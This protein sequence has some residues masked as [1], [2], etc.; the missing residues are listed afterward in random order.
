MSIDFVAQAKR[1]IILS[2]LF[3]HSKI[4]HQNMEHE[5]LFGSRKKR[6]HVTQDPW[7]LSAPLLWWAEGSPWTVGDSFQGTQIFGSTGSGKSSGSIATICRAFM[8]AGYGGLFLT[9]KA[10]DRETY[11]SYAKDAGRLDDVLVF[12][13][14]NDLKYNFI[15]DEQSQ[16]RG[17]DALVENL[18]ALLMTVTDLGSSGNEGGGGDNDKYFKLEGTRLARNGLLA[19]VLAGDTITIP[20]LHRLIVSSPTS[21]EQVASESWQQSSF[22]FKCL[23][24]ADKAEKTQSQ[25]AD[26]EL[27]LT[28]FLKEWPS[29]SSRT[30][31]VVQSTITSATDLLSRGI[32][33]D[34]ISSPTPNIS[35]SMM[36]EGKIII[37]DFPVLVYRDVGKMIQVILKIMWQRSHARRDIS[38]NNRP[39]FIV[40]DESQ[41]LLVDEDARFQAI[42]R[43]TRTAVV[44]ATQ[45]FSSYLETL[46]TNAEPKVNSLLTNLQLRICHQQTDVRTIQYMQDLLGKSPRFISN[47]NT[48]H[49]ENWL[50]PLIG[51]ERNSSSGFSE[52]WDNQI[53]SSDL[54][55]LA[56]GG[57][58][59]FKTEAIVYQGGKIFP[60]G[61][62]WIKTAFK[63][64]F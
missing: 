9:V 19:L 50:A 36:Y 32:A 18:T 62:T 14:Q 57:S 3:A 5:L 26:F 28:Y 13:P 25:Q 60:N 54:N 10:E 39:T 4:K 63:Q 31:S 43:S 20:D 33:R 29:L 2:K 34:M 41:L 49:N 37:A 30:R 15:A 17:S 61:N 55:S 6:K 1:N 51:G 59:H 16:S 38:K 56:K 8:R 22:C 27:A 42:A 45:S 48:N 7:D 23:K 47:G 46:G 58:P 24:T 21:M 52:Q 35:P 64:R 12:S 53:E 40:A 11:I 44:Y